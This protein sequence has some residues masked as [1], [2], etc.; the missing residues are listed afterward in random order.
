MKVKGQPLPVWV[1]LAQWAD[2]EFHEGREATFQWSS[3]LY[4]LP[5]LV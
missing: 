1:P 4:W 3:S 5:A 2:R